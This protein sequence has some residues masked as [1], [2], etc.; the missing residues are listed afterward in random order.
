MACRGARTGHVRIVIESLGKPG[1]AW[2]R[3]RGSS[4]DRVNLSENQRPTQ[5]VPR[6]NALPLGQPANLAKDLTSTDMDARR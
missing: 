5:S 4:F 3:P 2:K 6:M 1:L